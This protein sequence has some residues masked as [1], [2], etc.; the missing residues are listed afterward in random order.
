MASGALPPGFP[1]VRD[2]RRAVLGRRHR[3]E[4]AAVVRAR[5]RSEDERADP[6]GRRVQ[7]RA[8]TLPKN[9]AEVQE[10][11]KDIQYA[12][13]TR[14]NTNRVKELEALR[15][16]LRRVL[17]KLPRSAARRSRREDAGGGQHSRKAIS[18]VHF[19][20]RHHPRATSF[21]DCE[22]SRATVTDLW[23]AASATC[24]A[25][26]S[27][28][29]RMAAARPT[30]PKACAFSTCTPSARRT[31]THD[32]RRRRQRKRAF[33][34]PLTQPGVS[35]GP[36]PLRQSR[37]PRS[38]PTAPIPTRWRAVI[39]APLE[40]TEPIVKFEFIR[41]PDSTGFGDYTEA[42]QVIPVE[43]PRRARQLRALRCTSTD[44]PPIAGGRETLGLSEEAR[45]A[46]AARRE[47]H[48]RRHRCATARCRSRWPRWATSTARCR[49]TRSWPSLAAPNFLL[50]IIP[51][52]DGTPRIC[53][54][55]R[56]FCEDVTVKGAWEGPAALE[57]L[58]H[59]LAPV[60]SL[61]VREVMSGV[62]IHVRPDAR[63]RH[64]RSR[65]SRQPERNRHA[66]ARKDPPSSPAPPAASARRSPSP[67]RAKAPRSPSP[68]STSRPPTRPP[69]RS[70]RA[71]G[72][73]IGVAMDV[74]NEEAVN[75]GVAAA[76][77]AFGGVD[78][79]VSNA[80][81]QIVHPLE[82]FPYA[83]W[84]KMLAIHLDGAFLTTAP[85][86]STCTSRAAA[87]ASSTWARCT[88]RRPRCSRRPTSPPS[89]G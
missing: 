87:A 85:A 74:A 86:C 30:S 83:E 42:G 64:R 20:N 17:E 51:H 39:P 41:M 57:L 84:K 34:M 45:V 62:H 76:V 82:E 77:A 56:Y 80:G 58:H 48:D 4:L 43:L 46:G 38:S 32:D 89:T 7:R 63:A 68:T 78:I 67:T 61:P 9:L 2:R 28:N 18:L 53:E 50:K 73:A 24:A 27:P 13:K 3:V 33:A 47:G 6:P 37:I 29:P 25:S 19:I 23:E 1:P 5:R 10:R 36:V 40:M 88:P 49:T 54:L 12:S 72:K 70:R 35:A 71:G 52:V 66:T 60:A 14:F 8:A 16:S 44:E 31:S 65:L 81:I 21:K 69:P 55:V 59:A 26:R 22:F 79:L 15:A 11:A 75:A